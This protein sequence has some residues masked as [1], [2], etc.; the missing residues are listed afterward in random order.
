MV[1]GLEEES[2]LSAVDPYVR[3][4]EVDQKILSKVCYIQHGVLK[5]LGITCGSRSGRSVWSIGSGPLW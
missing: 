4:L 3:G 2:G 5:V 1:E